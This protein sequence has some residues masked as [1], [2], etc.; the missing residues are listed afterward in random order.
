MQVGRGQNHKLGVFIVASTGAFKPICRSNMMLICNVVF[1]CVS[2]TD[3]MA[4]RSDFVAKMSYIHFHCFLR[5]SQLAK[6]YRNWYDRLMQQFFSSSRRALDQM[7][8]Y[9]PACQDCKAAP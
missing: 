7:R 1:Q 8:S 6:I 2:T 9:S 5:R 4:N 3:R